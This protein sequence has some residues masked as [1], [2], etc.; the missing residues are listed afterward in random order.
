MPDATTTLITC[1]QC[2]LPQHP[3]ALSGGG[4]AHCARCNAL[5]YRHHPQGLE[6]SLAF[7]L[8]ALVCFIIGNAFPLL[9][10]EI[11]S[12]RVEARLIDTAWA[13]QRDGMGIVAGLLLLA[14]FIVPLIQ[15]LAMLYVLLPLQLGRRARLAAHIV[16]LLG[17]LRHW[18]MIEVFV[19]GALVALVKLQS[20]AQVV[21]GI[22]LWA[23]IGLMLSL[24]AAVV[25]FDPRHVA[26]RLAALQPEAAHP[27]FGES[28]PPGHLASVW[29]FVIAAAI[30]YIP[31]N[32]LP[33]MTTETLF[34]RQSDTILS[35]IAYLWH[36]GSWPLALIVFVASVAVPLLKLLALVLLAASVQWGLDWD[37]LQRTR[38]YR[39]VELVGKWSM[40]DVFVVAL[41][42]ALVQSKTLV[43]IT[44]GPAAFA[45][46]A[47]VVLTM[48][49]A[50]SFDPRQIW[51]HPENVHD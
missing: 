8:T 41:L 5:L 40:V 9:S 37:P 1:P 30:L 24:T 38:L 45:F 4:A 47:V 42:V 48:F 26:E 39:L 18:S 49:A 11:G 32:L 44:A 13:I 20:M 10:L 15:I 43:T 14:T 7:A 25:A 6:R 29:A 23:C 34:D 19:L 35:G 28:H 51:K 50:M 36:S 46:A 27:G 17:Q 12:D 2:D 16:P 31:A 21:P 22:A 33:I 3:I